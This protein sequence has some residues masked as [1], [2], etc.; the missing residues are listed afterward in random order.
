MG[1]AWSILQVIWRRNRPLHG[2]GQKPISR[3]FN[4]LDYLPSEVPSKGRDGDRTRE[5]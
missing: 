2:Y 4:R 3:Y 1:R 5:V